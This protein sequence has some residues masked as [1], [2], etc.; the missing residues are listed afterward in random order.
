MARSYLPKWHSDS[1]LLGIHGG[2]SIEGRRESH[3]IICPNNLKM[4]DILPTKN[5]HQCME[6]KTILKFGTNAPRPLTRWEVQMSGG[7]VGHFD[8][9]DLQHAGT[10]NAIHLC[11]AMHHVYKPNKPLTRLPLMHYYI[12]SSQLS[13]YSSWMLS[14]HMF[15]THSHEAG[16]E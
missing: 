3:E 14:G 7:L 15:Q 6:A 11:P 9:T 2:R 4:T 12:S 1:P 13:A 8:P 5:R 16:R 10:S